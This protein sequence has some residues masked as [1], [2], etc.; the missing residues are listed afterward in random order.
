MRSQIVEDGLGRTPARRNR[1]HDSHAQ[2]G[3]DT[4]TRED[5]SPL[6]GRNRSSPKSRQNSQDRQSYVNRQE[7]DAAGFQ[8]VFSRG[9][10]GG[11]GGLDLGAADNRE[12][13]RR[14]TDQVDRAEDDLGKAGWTH[15][16]M[17]AFEYSEK[18]EEEG[19]CS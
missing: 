19:H 11:R 5:Q 2:H 6:G 9:V 8:T 1:I 15:A 12:D 10:A 14:E 13:Q 16:R 18:D 3:Q 7:D 4:T 17:E